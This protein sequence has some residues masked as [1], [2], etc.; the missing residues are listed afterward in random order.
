MIFQQLGNK[1]KNRGIIGVR[2]GRLTNA[3]KE[4]EKKR[5]STA[6]G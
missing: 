6:A 2:S 3:K 5:S 1:K 4:K